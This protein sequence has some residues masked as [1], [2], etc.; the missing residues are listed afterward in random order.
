MPNKSPHNTKYKQV[1]DSL[2]SNKN[3]LISLLKFIFN[4]RLFS[5]ARTIMKTCKVSY[6]FS[7]V[8]TPR[9][10]RF[11]LPEVNE[12][13]QNDFTKTTS[14]PTSQQEHDSKGNR[15][16]STRYSSS[17]DLNGSRGHF[18]ARS[19]SPNQQEDGPKDSRWR[20]ARYSSSPEHIV[21]YVEIR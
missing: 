2:I 17:P 10:V 5:L 18:F 8:F 12:S 9:V 11:Y 4:Y 1:L 3:P 7:D 6:D 14:S 13:R 21:K 16:K 20:S 19:S 15:W